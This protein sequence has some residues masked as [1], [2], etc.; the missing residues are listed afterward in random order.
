MPCHRCAFSPASLSAL[1]ETL[2]SSDSLLQLQDDANAWRIVQG[3]VFGAAPGDAVVTQAHN[4]A[5][6]VL[7]GTDSGYAPLYI[8]TA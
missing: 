1:P 4:H 6:P 2:L 5:V 3:I 8:Q 7:E